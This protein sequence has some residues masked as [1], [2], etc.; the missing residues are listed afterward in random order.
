MPQEEW[1][2]MR[3]AGKPAGFENAFFIVHRGR[4]GSIGWRLNGNRAILSGDKTDPLFLAHGADVGGP[5]EREILS[6]IYFEKPGRLFFSRDVTLLRRILLD[7]QER[8]SVRIFLGYAGW[9]PG[10]LE[11]E[12]R[13]GLWKREDASLREALLNNRTD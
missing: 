3:A 11:K 5:V 1:F 12:F 7:S 2:L 6:F 4:Y 13:D 10:Q 8:T 9:A